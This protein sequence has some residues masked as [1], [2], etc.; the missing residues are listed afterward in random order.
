MKEDRCCGIPGRLLQYDNP[1]WEPLLAA[2]GE[3]LT[4]SFMW[5]H[6]EV[7]RGGVSLHAYKHTW[8]RR[9]LYLT[10][11]GRAFEYTPCGTYVRT[12]LDWAI[13]HALCVWWL[14]SGWEPEDHVAICEAYL[15][16]NDSSAGTIET[17]GE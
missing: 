11:D 9:Y 13:E 5:M 16:A 6:E 3:R 15:R 4:D 17:H 1:L 14:M 7:L 8:T 10:E 12:R 2:V